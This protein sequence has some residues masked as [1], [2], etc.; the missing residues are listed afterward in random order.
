VMSNLWHGYKERTYNDTEQ[1]TQISY[2][3]TVLK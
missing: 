1:F 2:K 3:I